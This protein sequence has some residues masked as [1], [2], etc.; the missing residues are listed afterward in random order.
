MNQGAAP[1]RTTPRL[2]DYR[3]EDAAALNAVALSAFAQFSEDYSDWP[4]MA[5][6]V[7]NMAA[8]SARGE[9]VV[10]EDDGRVAGGV[11]YVPPQGE[12]ADFFEPDWALIRMLVVAPEFRGLGLGRRLTEECLARA[13]R[14]GAARI[15]LHTTS[16]MSV[17]LPMYRRMGFRH[18]YPVAPILGVSY[19]VYALDL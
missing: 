2:R 12:R 10:A 5:E 15:A 3:A 13:R 4:A 18:L 6:G 19:D 7:S 14:D 9:I 11:V 1:R 16:I 8:L 17:A